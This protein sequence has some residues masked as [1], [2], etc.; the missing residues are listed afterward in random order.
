MRKEQI[1]KNFTKT[2]NHSVLKKHSKKTQLT[3]DFTVY[4][5]KVSNKIP[6]ENENVL[7]RLDGDIYLMAIMDSKNRWSI[8]WSDGRNLEDP[9]RP[10]THWM[11]VPLIEE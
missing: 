10:V 1:K 4:W 2:R 7:V 5:H 6:P 9:E 8:Y 11:S 3:K